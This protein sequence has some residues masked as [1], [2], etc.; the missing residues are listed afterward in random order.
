MGDGGREGAIERMRR[1][2]YDGTGVPSYIALLSID[3]NE[4]ASKVMAYWNMECPE[5]RAHPDDLGDHAPE[6]SHGRLQQSLALLEKS[7]KG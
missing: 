5:C 1:M 4:A 3:V 7:L 2:I 6:C